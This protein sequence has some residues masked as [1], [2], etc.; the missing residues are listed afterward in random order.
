MEESLKS[1]QDRRRRHP[2]TSSPAEEG[3]NSATR[4][5][6][7]HQL[8]PLIESMRRGG[9]PYP[10][11]RVMPLRLSATATARVNRQPQLLGSYENA[12][13]TSSSASPTAN[14]NSSQPL[15]NM[16]CKDEPTLPK[17]TRPLTRVKASG[18]GLTTSDSDPM[19]MRTWYD[20]AKANCRRPPHGRPSLPNDG[21]PEIDAC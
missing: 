2:T 20:W 9:R 19:Y 11:S 18:R 16:S 6:N 21:K 7:R 12:Y 10:L 1:A 13:A 14:S 8:R 15:I 5:S 17:T 4:Y 3:V